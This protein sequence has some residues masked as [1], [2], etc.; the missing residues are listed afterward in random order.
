M[1]SVGFI[2]RRSSLGPASC[3][4]GGSVGGVVIAPRTLVGG[5][6]S[7]AM[8]AVVWML[9]LVYEWTV[10][11]PLRSFYFEGPIWHNQPPEEICYGMTGVEAR[12]WTSSDENAIQCAI[13]M[14][15][16]FHSW[17]RT[18]MTVIYFTMLT[19]ILL[20]VACCCVFGRWSSRRSSDDIGGG[21][22]PR[23]GCRTIDDTNSRF[24]T[25]AEFDALLEGSGGRCRRPSPHP[26]S[27]PPSPAS[28][29]PS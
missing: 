4:S 5:M 1:S 3:A 15:R 2:A 19:V 20:R 10:T 29:I 8:G 24:V 22:G 26:P 6:L 9:W 18:L 25:R 17:D 21:G 16:R 13:E 14:E 12:H 7:D 27:R 11:R 28:E 23:C